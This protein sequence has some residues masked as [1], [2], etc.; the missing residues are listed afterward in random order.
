MQG[1]FGVDCREKMMG[2]HPNA[3]GKRAEAPPEASTRRSSA[4]PPWKRALDLLCLL[5]IAPVLG[6]I[7]FIIA[8]GI[9]LSSTGPILF[10]QERI[11]YKGQPFTCFKFRTMRDAAETQLHKEYLEKLINSDTPMEKL[12]VQDP[13]V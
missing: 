11:G 8:L 12:D 13:R 9:R 2:T 7:M 5:F 3:Q 6:P 1:L 10:R 4:L